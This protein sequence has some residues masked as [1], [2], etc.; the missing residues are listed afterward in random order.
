MRKYTNIIYF[1]CIKNTSKTPY[2]P[3]I[4][5]FFTHSQFREQLRKKIYPILCNS[6]VQVGFALQL[7][8]CII[9]AFI[10]LI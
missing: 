3:G 6:N 5:S 2:L 8:K 9:K 10:H 1:M 7:S 4:S